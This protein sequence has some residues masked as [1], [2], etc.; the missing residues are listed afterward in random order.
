MCPPSPTGAV[1]SIQSLGTLDGPGVRYVVFLQGCPLRCGCCHNP[2]TWDAKDGKC[3]AAAELVEKALHYREY[4]GDAGGV[5]LSGGE[6]LLQPI[7]AEA[8]FRLAREAGL[9]TCLDTSGC[10][11]NDEV[12]ALLSVSDRVLLD[13]KYPTDALY[14]EYVGCSLDAPLA[15]LDYLQ[16]K[17]ITTT[18]RTVLIP[19]L[20]DTRDHEEFLSSLV[21]AHPCIDTVEVLPFRKL[22]T[23]KY[24]KM[25]IPFRFAAIPEESK[26]EARAMQD[27]I[28]KLLTK[29]DPSH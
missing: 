6:P 9:H 5:T 16:E 11:L 10:I 27:R 12:E 2:D 14:R 18:L 26:A 3:Y 7:F 17:E 25:G 23:V 8:F 28:S 4:F 1:H 20:N 24:D 22:C 15:F 29:K 19:S 13:I 21:K